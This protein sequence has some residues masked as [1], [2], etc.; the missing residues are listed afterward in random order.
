VD[1]LTGDL[2]VETLSERTH[3]SPRNFARVFA[4]EVGQ[5][6][7]RYIDTI[8][9]EAAQRRLE[10]STDSLDEIATQCGFGSANSM[11]R[12]FLRVRGVA[13]STYRERFSRHC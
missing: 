5:T 3:M 7:A 9:V 8:R 12:S 6:P 2:T 13:P 1:N 11:R 10:E 4:R